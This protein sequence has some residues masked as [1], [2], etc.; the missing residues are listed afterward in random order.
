[1][2]YLEIA[3]QAEAKLRA[4]RASHAGDERNEVTKEAATLS[5]DPRVPEHIVKYRAAVAA[6]LVDDFGRH[7]D[8]HEVRVPGVPE[9]LFVV[10]TAAEGE[11]LAVRER[12]TRGRIWTA[13]ELADMLQSSATVKDFAA[14]ALAKLVLD[15]E[16]VG[17]RPRLAR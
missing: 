10:P 14:V 3:K 8:V 15:G 6:A 4:A 13:R 17:V 2:S 1:M 9:T 5:L 12:I 11:H 7:G 16:V